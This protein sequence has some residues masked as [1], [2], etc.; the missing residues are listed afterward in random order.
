ML[1][2]VEELTDD[3]DWS[4]GDEEIDVESFKN[5]LVVTKSAGSFNVDSDNDDDD[6]WSDDE[7]VDVN[8][9]KQSAAA[10]K[11]G[12]SFSLDDDDGWE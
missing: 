1:K 7:E 6:D 2:E 9:F 4:D 12:G 8:A 10:T 11:S 5:S 3:D